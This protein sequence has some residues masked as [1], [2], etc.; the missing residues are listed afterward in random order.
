MKALKHIQILLLLTVLLPFQVFP[1]QGGNTEELQLEAIVKTFDAVFQNDAYAENLTSASLNVLPVGIK[2]VVN[3]MEVTIAVDKAEFC[4]DYTELTLFAKAVLPQKSADGRPTTL[5]FGAR[6]IKLSHKGTII[7]DATLALLEDVTIRFN[8]GNMSVTLLGNYDKQT[9]NTRS[10]TYLSVDCLG[11]KEL[12]LDAEVRFPTTLVERVGPDGTVVQKNPVVSGHFRTV[13]SDWNNIMADITLPSFQ[14]CGL[15][16]FIFDLEKVLLDFSDTYNDK[17]VAFPRGYEQKYMIPG[18]PTL[19]RGVYARRLQVTL[20]KAFSSTDGTRT[21][22]TAEHMLIDDNGITGLFAAE[23]ILRF[24]NGSA[25]GWNFSVNTFRLE[26]EANQLLAAGFSGEIGLPFNKGKT[27]LGYN[28]LI[29]EDNEYLMCVQP[30]DTLDFSIFNA[31]ATLLPNSYVKLHVVDNKFLPEALLHG[32]MAIAAGGKV[33]V[34]IP[35]LEFQS[36]CLKTEDPY[37]SIKYLGYKGKVSLGAFPISLDNIALRS[38][39]GKVELSSGIKVTLGQDMFSGS[40]NIAFL[41]SL[42]EEGDRRSWDFD[43]VKVNEIALGADI[44]GTMKINGTIGWRRDDPVYGD[45][46]YGALEVAIKPCGDLNVKMRGCF[47]RTDGFS[48]WFVDGSVKLPTPIPIVGPLRISGFAG[49]VSQKMI[50]V[51]NA[52][53]EGSAFA[54]AAYLPDKEKGFG[55]KSSVL[56]DIAKVGSGEACFDIAFN[57]RGGLSYIGF[58]GHVL[59]A[60]KLNNTDVLGLTDKYNQVLQKEKEYASKMSTLDRLKQFEPNKA[61]EI[62]MPVPEKIQLGIKGAVGIKYDFDN[63]I[64]H[65]QSDLSINI[66]GGI[67][68]GGG[69][70]VI[71]F[72]PDTWYMHIG[73]PDNRMGLKLNIG[74]LLNVQVGSYLMVGSEIPAMPAPPVEVATI[75]GRDLSSLTLGRNFDMLSTGKGFAFGADLRVATGDITFL[76]LYANFLT[77]MGFDIMFKDFGDMYCQETGRQ[78]GMNGW[79]AQGQSYAYL[80]GELGVK[81]NLWFLKMTFPI[82]KGSTAA[83]LQAQLPNPSS[84]RGYLGVHVDVLGL[85]K[86]NMRF[87]LSLGDDCTPLIPGGSPLQM[88]MISDIAPSDKDSDISVFATPQVTFT[89]ALDTQFQAEDDRGINTY[90]VRLKAF[91]LQSDGGEVIP[92]TLKWNSDKN[93]VTFQAKEVLPPYA[94][95][96]ARV[97]VCFDKFSNGK[98]STVYTANKEAVETRECTFTTGG[99]PDNIPLEN[100]VYSYPVVDQRYF[101]TAEYREGAV[102]LQFGQKYLFERGF[103]YKLAFTGEDGEPVAAD[104]R[105]NEQANRIEYS[106]PKLNTQQRYTLSLSYTPK[107]VEVADRQGTVQQVFDTEEE[108]ALSVENRGA[109]AGINTTLEKSI[110]DF[111]FATSRYTTFGEKLGSIHVEGNGIAQDAGLSYRFLYNVQADE[112]FDEAEVTGVAKSGQKALIQPFARLEEPFFTHTVDPLVYEGYPFEAIRLAYRDDAGIGVPPVRSVFIYD[113]YLDL[114]ADD[115]R[116]PKFYL[117]W[118]YESG[119]VVERDFRDLQS[120]VVNNRTRVS[121]GIYKRFATGSLPFIKYGKYGVVMIYTLPDGTVT[122][123]CDFY[124]NNFLRFNE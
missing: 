14:I 12:G 34:S 98:W 49:A 103:D 120:Q 122:S 18:Q 119:I 45:G 65:A 6:G 118:A 13:V 82:I 46:F 29:Q 68:T 88:A 41:A 94:N 74:N 89:T 72:A 2:R 35:K 105:Y 97:E 69:Q 123:S 10:K 31:K 59:L 75:L 21:R 23:N 20:P 44:A 52:P 107:D 73:K 83:L 37:I 77:G 36:L 4:L 47:G 32:S 3:N 114:I 87:K 11:F 90:R 7:G 85:I 40:T 27:R 116:P 76:L 42:R 115:A 102:Q 39:S 61:A 66:P 19:W 28:A 53:N 110:L 78:V 124:F 112:P 86:G 91:T 121:E 100:I 63:H 51:G 26:M 56:L 22:F 54:A 92:G 38:T 67:L 111:G 50:G 101:L 30:A 109:S 25:G 8:G 1:Q 64:F 106:L 81:V 117:P 108:G 24:E 58:Y 99:A 93:A 57:A 33:P 16:G 84:F 55:L 104:F 60:A 9:G 70:S 15:D 17:A 62:V 95:L 79:F 96:T 43:E 113:P 5:F 80:Q 48:Y 71:H